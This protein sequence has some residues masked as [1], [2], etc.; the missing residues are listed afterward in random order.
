MIHK[1]NSSLWAVGLAALSLQ[2]TLRSS[3]F[4]GNGGRLRRSGRL[5]G[6]QYRRQPDHRQS[7][8]E[9]GSSVTGFPPGVVVP[10]GTHARRRC[11]RRSGPSRHHY[12]LQRL[13]ATP[14]LTDLTGT[15]LGNLVLTPSVYGFANSAQLTGT[16]TLDALGDPDAVF[17]FKIASTLTTA[18]G[19]AVLV[20]NG[21]S[22]C[23]VYWQIGSSATLGSGTA[24]AGNL[25][26]FTSITLTSGSSIS[27]RA[28]A[29][30]G[31]VTLST[32]SVADLP[33][34]AGPLP[35]HHDQPGDPAA[36]R[37]RHPLQSGS[38]RLRQHRAALYLHHFE[39]VAAGRAFAGSRH[40]SHQRNA[41]PARHLQFH[42]HR[43]RRGRLRRQPALLIVI[44]AFGCPPIVLSPPTLPDG[45]LG[46]PYS[47]FISA[48]GGLAP[49]AY[50]VSSGNLPTG[51][52]LNGI[53]GEIAGTPTEAGIFNFS[54]TAT[55]AEGC[56]GISSYV[57]TIG[58]TVTDI[59]TLSRWGQLL[60]AALCGMAAILLLRRSGS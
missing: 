19:S 48:S 3:D 29:R 4:F 38:G 51:L 15:D 5:H 57:V 23:N 1:K 60:M 46:Q 49:Y 39:R 13:V 21:G 26:A 10:P 14:T 47:E 28:L 22:P 24:F 33:A 41:D 45:E 44:A 11:D 37:R 2:L 55:D 53:T 34:R 16:L 50:T 27:G 40:R 6:D 17:I 54:I 36:R 25:L 31:A 7:R 12:R 52:M 56:P 20:I 35:D 59:P 9:P 18:N 42:R 32:N 30:N 43:H 58:G 8:A